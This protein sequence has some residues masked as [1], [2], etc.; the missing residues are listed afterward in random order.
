M[1]PHTLKIILKIDE[2]KTKANRE[3]ESQTRN[4]ILMELESKREPLLED[5]AAQQEI[6]D[7]IVALE[8]SDMTTSAGV[9]LAETGEF[10]LQEDYIVGDGGT[11]DDGNKDTSAQNEL[12][13]DADDS[14]LDFS[15]SNPFGDVGGSS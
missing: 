14:V 6:E 8:T 11:S 5:K 1:H 12:F 10:L 2:L 9:L 13:E 15:E 3:P 7:E 4:S